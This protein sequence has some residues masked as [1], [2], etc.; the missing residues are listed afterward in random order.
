MYPREG[1]ELI[2]FEDKGAVLEGRMGAL[3]TQPTPQ[4][5]TQAGTKHPDVG[6][7]LG[8]ESAYRDC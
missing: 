3:M 1:D 6:T 5:I 7:V 2:I 4:G 8:L